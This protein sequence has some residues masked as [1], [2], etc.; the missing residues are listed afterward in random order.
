MLQ[1]ETTSHPTVKKP[2]TKYPQNQQTNPNFSKNPNN[3]TTTNTNTNTVNA[4]PETETGKEKFENLYDDKMPLNKLRDQAVIT[5]KTI[6]MFNDSFTSLNSFSIENDVS[7]KDHV[8]LS[9]YN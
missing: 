8:N 5:L 7:S 2:I 1:L 6:D 9:K 4:H 3:P